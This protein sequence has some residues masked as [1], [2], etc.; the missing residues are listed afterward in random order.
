MLITLAVLVALSG[1]FAFSQIAADTAV[2]APAVAPGA[3]VIGYLFANVVPLLTAWVAR[4]Y[5]LGQ[6]WYASLN[7]GVKM[8][9]YVGGTVLVMY[10]CQFIALGLPDNLDVTNL[11]ADFLGKLV[12]ASVST[13]LV[14]LGIST[15]RAKPMPDA[16]AM[17]S[18]S[19]TRI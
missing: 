18:T 14:K 6:G 7:N 4:K 9:V 2:V 17:R 1:L 3:W 10:L 16:P 8:A 15:G 13:L 11:G 19:S 12:Y 5:N